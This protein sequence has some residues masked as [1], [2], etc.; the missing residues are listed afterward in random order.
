MIFT[1]TPTSRGIPSFRVSLP[2]PEGRLHFAHKSYAAKKANEFSIREL[3]CRFID[4][5]DVLSSKD[6]AQ[7]VNEAV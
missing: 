6:F 7:I 5:L 3:L 2:V 1:G 4:M